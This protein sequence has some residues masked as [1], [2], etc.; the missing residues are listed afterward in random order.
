LRVLSLLAVG[1]VG[2]LSLGFVTLIPNEPAAPAF[3]Q[4]KPRV[5]CFSYIPSEKMELCS[6]G[7]ARMN[8]V[9]IGPLTPIPGVPMQ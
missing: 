4:P 5:K 9:D 1:L 6:N 7:R 8:G 3:T 2:V